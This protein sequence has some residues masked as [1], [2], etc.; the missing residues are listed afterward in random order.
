MPYKLREAR[1]E[2]ESGRRTTIYTC[3]ESIDEGSIGIIYSIEKVRIVLKE[4]S[5]WDIYGIDP[6]SI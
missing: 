3:I 1:E 4:V 5:S 2:L 6:Q